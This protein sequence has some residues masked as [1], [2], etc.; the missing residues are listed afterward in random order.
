[1][2]ENL[3]MVEVGEPLCRKAF[4]QLALNDHILHLMPEQF[5]VDVA[6]HRGL[7]HGER[8][9]RTLHPGRK[10]QGQGP[11]RPWSVWCEAWQLQMRIIQMVE[12]A[13]VPPAEHCKTDAVVPAG[14]RWTYLSKEVDFHTKSTWKL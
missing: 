8:F 7:I 5:V 10:T 3:R 12:A 13:A 11:A 2:G 14:V 9:Q 6:R 1:M 4:W